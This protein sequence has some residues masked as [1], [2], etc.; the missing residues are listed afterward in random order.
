FSRDW[1]SDVCSSDLLDSRADITT[2][3][4]AFTAMVRNAMFR[5][6]RALS[7]R[8]WEDAADAVSAPEDEPAWTAER[9][10]AALAPYFDTHGAILD[11]KSV[12]EGKRVEV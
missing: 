10:E 11:R 9:L 7:R 5:L 1:S 2:D 6:V 4:R 12:V 8:S 3:R